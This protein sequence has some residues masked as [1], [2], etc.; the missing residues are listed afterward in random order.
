MLVPTH[1]ITALLQSMG[2]KRD[3]SPL[4]QNA[5]FREPNGGWLMIDE[6][7]HSQDTNHPIEDCVDNKC[8]QMAAIIKNYAED[9]LKALAKKTK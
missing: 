6:S 4:F 9:K 1:E 5:G 8:Y 3:A 2:M 7:H